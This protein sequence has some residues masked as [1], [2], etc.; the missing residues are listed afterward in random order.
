[1]R[2]RGK[3]DLLI[4]RTDLL[5]FQGH[6]GPGCGNQPLFALLLFAHAVQLFELLFVFAL[7]FGDLL[8]ELIELFLRIR[9]LQKNEKAPKRN[10][11]KMKRQFSRKEGHSR[12][13]DAPLWRPKTPKSK[14]IIPGLHRLRCCLARLPRL[15]SSPAQDT[16]FL[17]VAIYLHG[18]HENEKRGDTCCSPQFSFFILKNVPSLLA[19]L[20]ALALWRYE[21]SSG[22]RVKKKE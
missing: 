5:V 17:P 22:G 11:P 13:R 15:H 20:Q 3:N 9:T 10:N 21:I 8:V 12:F 14:P 2:Q 6:A 4:F 18:K 19:H 7:V 16:T 1:M